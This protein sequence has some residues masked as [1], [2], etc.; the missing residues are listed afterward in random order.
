MT[1]LS[2]FFVHAEAGMQDVLCNAL[3]DG[4]VVSFELHGDEGGSWRVERAGLG[5]TVRPGRPDRADCRLI[6]AASDFRL[7]M[8]GELGSR[9]GFMQGRLKVEG[10]IG[11]VLK[12]EAAI[13]R[14]PRNFSL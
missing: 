12:L 8:R 1:P 6:C 7:L 9:E 11:L 3:P 5:V 14:R 4:V 2:D 10:D 13:N